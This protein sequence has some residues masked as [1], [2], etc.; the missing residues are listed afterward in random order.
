MRCH[1]DNGLWDLSEP[2]TCDLVKGTGNIPLVHLEWGATN[3]P[4][5]AVVDSV[6]RVTIVSF[7]ISLN[8]P[9]ITRKWDADPVD[10]LNAIAGCYWLAVAPSNQ[11]VTFLATPLALEDSD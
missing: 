3:S 10:D 7:S 4:E 11:Q 5:L 1:P 2:T 9:F 8:H 6:G